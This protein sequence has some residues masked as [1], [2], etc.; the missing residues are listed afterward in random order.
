VDWILDP[1][2]GVGERTRFPTLYCHDQMF[3]F[4]SM[5]ITD[6]DLEGR[7][8]LKEVMFTVQSHLKVKINLIEQGELQ[9]IT[10]EG[11]MLLNETL[12]NESTIP[13]LTGITHIDKLFESRQGWEDEE[14]LKRRLSN[15]DSDRKG[16]AK[17]YITSRGM[18]DLN[19]RW[20]VC[21]VPSRPFVAPTGE[22]FQVPEFPERL[23]NEIKTGVDIKEWILTRLTDYSNQITENY[24][25][26]KD[27][28]L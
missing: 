26:S 19:P 11:I 3:I 7:P 22:V 10:P 16:G 8:N 12:H 13:T 15:E 25:E 4:D 1:G 14:P 24:N 23:K 17:P 9:R 18:G 21:L 28:T 27:N 2:Y 20:W 6:K 5:G